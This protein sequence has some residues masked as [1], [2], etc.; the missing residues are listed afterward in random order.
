MASKQ[1]EA[2]KVFYFEMFFLRY[3]AYAQYDK[4]LKYFLTHKN[5]SAKEAKGK[6]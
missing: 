5:Q 4:Y 3:F 6:F 1:M 2:E